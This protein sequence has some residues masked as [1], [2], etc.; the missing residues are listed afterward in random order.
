MDQ[1]D[2]LLKIIPEQNKKYFLEY[3]KLHN[4]NKLLKEQLNK[5]TKEKNNMKLQIQ[6]EEVY[7]SSSNRIK[8]LKKK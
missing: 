6:K 8:Q 1:T 5:L 4:A 3:V 2:S 7:I